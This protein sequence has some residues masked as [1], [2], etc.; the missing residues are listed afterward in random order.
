MWTL[1]RREK[2]LAPVGNQ[3]LAVQPLDS[4]Y[5]DLA[6]PKLR[7]KTTLIIMVCPCVDIDFKK[8]D[9]E[10]MSWRRH[11]QLTASVP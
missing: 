10:K 2:S 1:W 11:L 5:T 8:G 9:I 7:L 4:L 6:T 3:T